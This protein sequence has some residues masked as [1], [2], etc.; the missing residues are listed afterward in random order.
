MLFWPSGERPLFQPEMKFQ[1]S[2][3]SFWPQKCSVKPSSVCSNVVFSLSS[4][5]DHHRP[6]SPGRRTDSGLTCPG[7]AVAL[8]LLFED[9]VAVFQSLHVLDHQSAVWMHGLG[10]KH[11]HTHTPVKH[12]PVIHFKRRISPRFM[13]KT[14]AVICTIILI[15][16][17]FLF[18]LILFS[19]A[20]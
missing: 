14:R 10:L 11:T 13:G 7:G 17:V 9:L 18:S 8:L 20:I 2:D 3:F 19:L 4:S 5:A 12:P 16:V 6:P 15:I 1:D